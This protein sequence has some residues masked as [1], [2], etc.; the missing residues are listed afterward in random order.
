MAGRAKISAA[1]QSTI[2]EYIAAAMNTL[3]KP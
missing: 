3:K 1:Q 2:L